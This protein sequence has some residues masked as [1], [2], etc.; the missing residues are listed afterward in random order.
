MKYSLTENQYRYGFRLRPFSLS[1]GRLDEL[2][3][4]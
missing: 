1:E 3:K 4:R 2:L